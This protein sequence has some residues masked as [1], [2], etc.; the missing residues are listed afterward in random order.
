[1]AEI[2]E[3]LSEF[4]GGQFESAEHLLP[5]LYD[6]L[7]KLAAQKLTHERPGQTLDA[8]GLVHEA[9]VRLVESQRLTPW[10]SRAHFFAAAAEAMRRILIENAR[11]KASGKRGGGLRRCEMDLVFE[12][13]NEPDVDLVALDEALRRLEHEQPEKARVVKLKFFAGCTLEETADMLAI[14][15][16]TAQRHWTYARAWLYGQICDR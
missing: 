12:V 14:S 5:L 1:M 8:T 10:Q 7:R 15:R 9:F 11:R 16:A 4:A 2:T 3:I 13:A 6:E